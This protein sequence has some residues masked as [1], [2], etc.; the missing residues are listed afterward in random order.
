MNRFVLGL[1]LPILLIITPASAQERET[2]FS[3]NQVSHGAFA[4][5]LGKFSQISG[6]SATF[7]GGKAAWLIN[8]SYYVGGGGFTTLGDIKITDDAK[9]E[10]KY[11]LVYGGFLV[12]YIYEQHKYLHY[13]YDILVGK[14]SLSAKGDSDKPDDGLLLFEPSFDVSLGL[15]K[16][17]DFNIGVSYRYVIGSSSDDKKLSNGKMSSLALNLSINFGKF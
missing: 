11:G 14:G 5:L 1:L 15:S 3:N 13:Y 17:A 9:A 2:L 16:Y 4:G 6:E 8:H 10:T 7:A 12:G